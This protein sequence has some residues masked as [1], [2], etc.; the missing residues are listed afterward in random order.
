MRNVVLIATF[1]AAL[2][3]AAGAQAPAARP[4]NYYAAGN[5]VDI[6]APMAAD[7]IVAGR[8]VTIRQPVA[9]DIA[10]A[11][12]R[13]ELSAKADDD[14][15]LAGMDVLIDAPVTGDVTVAGGTVTLGPHAI[16]GGRSWITGNTVHIDGVLERGVSVAAANVIITGEIRQPVRV[17]AERFEVGKGARLLAP[18]SYR[19]PSEAIVADGATIAGPMTYTRIETHEVRQARQMPLASTVLFSTH[20][21]LAGLLVIAFLPRTKAS[22]V[23]T[24]QRQPLTSVLAGFTLLVTVPVAALVLI[25]SVLGLPFGLML[26]ALYA[27]LMFAGVLTTAFFLGEWEARLFKAG[28]VVSR[29]RQ[30]LLLLAGVLT[31]ALL[32]SVVGGLIVL[33]SIVFGLGA[34]AVWFHREVVRAPQTPVSA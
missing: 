29:R 3:T 18:V 8:D 32:R 5:R 33:A 15:R 19:G 16:V 26:I 27:V 20:L 31:L 28:P 25:G 34:L 23:E 1:V 6:A 17:I 21:F 13:L 12:W 30:L 7:V 22:I 14:V 2:G 11:A 10:A 4:D 9:G 24:L